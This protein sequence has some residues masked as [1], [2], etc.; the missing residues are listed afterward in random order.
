MVAHLTA[1]EVA[2]RWPAPEVVRDAAAIGASATDAMGLLA[3]ALGALATGDADATIAMA[4]RA[5]HDYWATPPDISPDQRGVVALAFALTLGRSGAISAAAWRATLQTT[6]ADLPGGLF[7]LVLTIFLSAAERNSDVLDLVRRSAATAKRDDVAVWL[8]WY[9]IE[10]ATAQDLGTVGLDFAKLAHD[11]AARSASPALIAVAAATEVLAHL[12]LG[13]KSTAEARLAQVLQARSDQL[14]SSGRAMVSLAEGLY[15]HQ[16]GHDERAIQPLQAAAALSRTLPRIEQLTLGAYAT[17]LEQLGHLPP[18][19]AILRRLMTVK[20]AVQRTTTRH[21][22]DT[23][24]ESKRTNERLA[25]IVEFSSELMVV[26]DDDGV[27]RWC[28][29]STPHIIGRPAETLI[30]TILSPEEQEHVG[31]VLNRTAPSN[32]RRVTGHD[33]RARFLSTSAR[34]FRTAPAIG[35]VLVSTTDVTVDHLER[36]MLAGQVNVLSSIEASAT[37]EEPLAT[38]SRA[39]EEVVGLGAVVSID[40]LG[41]R[42][43]AQAGIIVNELVSDGTVIGRLTIDR[44]MVSIENPVTD[45][46]VA[47]CVQ[48]ATLALRSPHGG[49]GGSDVL[50]IVERQLRERS[51]GLVL[52]QIDRI[53]HLR[54]RIGTTSLEEYLHACDAAL[55]VTAGTAAWMGQVGHRHVVAVSSA[56]GAEMSALAVSLQEAMAAAW[57][58][59]SFDRSGRAPTASAGTAWAAAGTSF[60]E[61]FQFSEVAL[62]EAKRRGNGIVVGFDEPT[63]RREAEAV[64]LEAELASSI[65]DG[66]LMVVYQPT[67]SLLDGTVTA[68]EALVRWNHPEHG[69]VPPHRFLPIAETAGLLGPL[70]RHVLAESLYASAVVAQSAGRIPISI[71]VAASQVSDPDEVRE[72]IAMLAEAAPTGAEVQFEIGVEALEDP[73]VQVGLRRL[74]DAGATIVLDDVGASTSGLL[75]LATIDADE[76]KL[77][78]QLLGLA[79]EGDMAARRAL[80]AIS[81]GA[82]ALGVSVTGKG[83]EDQAHE[84][85]ARELGCDGVLGWLHAAPMSLAE[86]LQ[87]LVGRTA[88]KSF[89]YISARAAE[90]PMATGLA[91]T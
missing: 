19:N 88:I 39:I 46:L 22:D 18:A 60:D 36:I 73:E 55:R 38:A 83:V 82:S 8:L 42:S 31:R 91:A 2:L 17:C 70:G 10:A 34:D 90:S 14:A 85:M 27:I 84:D 65:T 24:A 81:A 9:G 21:V 15:L 87:W 5:W 40:R 89:D 33:G 53:N 45:E 59:G 6:P 7:E 35:G 80:R 62:A 64:R 4:N 30:G 13:D 77:H 75:G 23:L 26:V 74:R 63:A 29:P 41:G 20:Q 12:H 44:R 32:I 68:L 66:E 58:T 49:S 52:L 79:T 69:P 61:L 86:L 16:A 50:G 1:A 78:P 11:R 48:L 76:I 71:N 56:D 25:A 3:G 54:T 43:P 28:S 57:K 37:K 47:R 67:V 72:L 51:L